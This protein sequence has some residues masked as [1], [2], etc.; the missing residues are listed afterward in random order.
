MGLKNLTKMFET[1]QHWSSG[2]I[3][4]Q[5]NSPLFFIAVFFL[6]L[7]AAV[8]S[9]CNIGVVAAVTGYAGAGSQGVK[10]ESHLKTGL[11]FFLGNVISLSLLGAVTGFVSE[12]IGSTVGQFWTLIAG[13]LV[14]YLGLMSLKM[15]PFDLKIESKLNSKLSRISNKGLVFGLA[16]GGFATACSASCNPIFPIILGTSFLQGSMMLSWFT[17]FV[18]AIGYSLPLGGILAGAGFGFE[19]FSKKIVRNQ[20][21]ISEVF[22]V[23]LV[24]TGFGLLMG[25]V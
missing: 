8:G 7:V 6:G 14:V 10:N 5:L 15:L 2:I 24:V 1:I 4:N 19:K 18:F 11:S 12:S 23:I 21:M 20:K 13:V 25:W 9:C 16:L 3:G 17:L 22:G